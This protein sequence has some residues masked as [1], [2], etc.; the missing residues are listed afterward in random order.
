MTSPIDAVRQAL[1]ARGT[2]A[3]QTKQGWIGKCPAHD[4]KKASLSLRVGDD[5]RALVNCF[6]GC[7][8]AAITAALGLEVSAMFPAVEAPA[9]RP[10][11]GM[12]VAAAY[13]YTDAAGTALYEVLRC[14]P[15]DFRQRRPDGCGGW[16]WG[17]G[18]VPRGL[19]R[20]PEVVAAAAKGATVYVVEGEKD[21]DNLRALGLVATTA[22]GGA[23]AA[24]TQAHTK[25]LRGAS[26]V[27]LP[28]NDDP[29]REHAAKVQ[30]ALRAAGIVVRVVALPGLS[31]KGDVSDWLEARDGRDDAAIVEE[32]RALEW[33]EGAL[34]AAWKRVPVSYLT[35]VPPLR[36]WLVRHPTKDW[37]PCLPGC[38]DGMLPRGKVGAILAEGGAGKTSILIS[39]ALSLLS[40][41]RWLDH[42]EP[43]GEAREGQILLLLGEEDTEEVWRR[44]YA[45]G[46]ALGLREA[47]QQAISE[48][49]TVLPLAGV[50]CPFMA[51]ADDGKTLLETQALSD[52]RDLLARTAGPA[53]WSL[54]AVDPLSRFAGPT[55]EIDNAAATRFVQGLETLT[56]APGAPTVLV[57][58]HSTKAARSE[59]RADARGSSALTDAL[60][61]TASLCVDESDVLF[62]QVKSNYS[63]PMPD[64]LRLVRADG[65]ALR[66][67]TESE[68]FAREEEL[69]S[70]QDA[71]ARAKLAAKEG[72]IEAHQAAL[73]QAVLEARSEITS[74]RAL[75][76]LVP[77]KTEEKQDAIAR[78]FRDGKLAKAGDQ[79]VVPGA[80][81]RPIAPRS[82]PPHPGPH[83][84][85]ENPL[86]APG[87]AAT[88]PR[89][90]GA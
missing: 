41:R 81:E 66:V 17:R 79:I 43:E 76:G 72:R 22:C 29:G 82:T 61:W 88:A 90:P 13:Q 8:F 12:K 58:H 68:A 14:E 80:P 23:S 62:R 63:R 45:S 48:R 67:P 65:G 75:A 57:L 51:L 37:Q 7:D 38:G 85:A 4:D 25:P 44:V 39:L 87:G 10:S 30:A 73:I 34:S 24:W 86:S 74:Q 64:D 83:P 50:A 49:L 33:P 77:G 36:R 1:D 40:G 18:D 42:F 27:V 5:G 78:L 53:G 54:V 28:D 71:R 60:R 11:N 31:E 35:E 6:A 69:E 3:R 52:L 15:K 46:R 9:P 47:D 59:G 2:P 56:G 19:Y 84:G 70:V 55:A 21:V 16:T 32:L 26:V 89:T 20:L